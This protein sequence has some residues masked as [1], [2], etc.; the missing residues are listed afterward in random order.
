MKTIRNILFLLLL[1]IFVLAQDFKVELHGTVTDDAVQ[2][3]WSCTGWAKEIGGFNIKRRIL[4][5]NTN[6]ELLNAQPIEPALSLNKD[7]TRQGLT[8]EQTEL[9]KNAIKTLQAGNPIEYTTTEFLDLLLNTNGLQSGDRLRMK[10]DFEQALIFGFGYI[11]NTY[12]KKQDYEYAVFQ[13]NRNGKEQK[14]PLALYNTANLKDQKIDI[15]F[16]HIGQK[17]Q[18]E[19]E[20]NKDKLNDIPFGFNI[21][22]KEGKEFKLLVSNPLDRVGEDEKVIRYTFRDDDSDLNKNYTYAIA[23]VTMFQTEGEKTIKKYDPKKHKP[24]TAP[25]ID[26]IRAIEKVGI[27]LKWNAKDDRIKSISIERKDKVEGDFK[28][29]EKTNTKTT[30]WTDKK[31][32]TPLNTYTYRLK[33]V[34]KND[35]I[36]YSEERSIFY[37]G[38]KEPPKPRGFKGTIVQKAGQPNVRLTWQ[39]KAAIDKLTKGYILFSD[40]LQ[41][42]NLLQLTN[43]GMIEKTTHDYPIATQGGR[44][45]TFKV[46]PISVYDEQG[47]GAEITVYVEAKKMP[48]IN[49]FKI[50]LQPDNSVKLTWTY[51]ELREVKGFQVFVNDRKLV[52]HDK[53]KRKKRE[54]LLED[55]PP[56]NNRSYAIEM[57][58]VGN[59]KFSD[60]T[61][62][63][64]VQL[65]ANVE[66]TLKA[67]KGLEATVFK[68]KKQQ[69]VKITWKKVNLEKAKL[70]G[71]KIAAD[72]NEKGFIATIPNSGTIEG[73]EFEFVLNKK[74]F[75][76]RET[77]TFRLS[78]ISTKGKEGAYSE[79]IVDLKKKK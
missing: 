71:Y 54:Y 76:K 12:Q 29:V 68:E 39:V 3:L 47:E 20:L 69:K 30:E 55:L 36:G 22:R 35:Q 49:D 61:I 25:Q 24:F 4:K 64:F 78:G 21:Y 52:G 32:E 28:T 2:L 7:W 48:Y 38:L 43:I 17:N 10:R 40:E 50:A 13:V 9:V 62:K 74:I 56:A 37:M 41:K 60:K 59:G 46:V 34:Q 23:P 42:G 19:W 67:P 45:Y 57:R 65:K 15:S 58:A 26:S 14:K 1:P 77:I 16:N 44:E 63:R 66:K 33:F 8:T 6:W 73:N 5:P 11:D 70:K 27:L 72:Y 18:L 53:A 51:P 79:I 75:K 31:L